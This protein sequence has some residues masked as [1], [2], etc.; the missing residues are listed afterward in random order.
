MTTSTSS[1]AQTLRPSSTKRVAA[2]QRLVPADGAA[3]GPGPL[4]IEIGDR[5]HL[6]S[7]NRRHLRQEHGAELAGADQSGANRK[8]GF[9]ATAEEG[10]EVHGYGSVNLGRAAIRGPQDE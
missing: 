10:G 6:Q 4:R 2:D 1:A 7:R 9:G 8:A 5:R 3:R